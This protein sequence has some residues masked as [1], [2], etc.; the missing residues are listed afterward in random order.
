MQTTKTELIPTSIRLDPETLRQ[1]KQAAALKGTN[2]TDLIRLG[3]I[4]VL[5]LWDTEKTTVLQ[6]LME[7]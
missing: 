1:L 7:V 4:H 3:I 2:R 6:R 5:H